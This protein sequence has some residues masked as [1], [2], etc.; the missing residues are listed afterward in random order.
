MEEEYQSP[1]NAGPE[2]I[3]EFAPAASP[4]GG[5]TQTEES[6][7]APEP[8]FAASFLPT[9]QIFRDFGRL[10]VKKAPL[11]R[12]YLI[13][14]LLCCLAYAVLTLVFGPSWLFLLGAGAVWLLLWMFMGEI[15][16]GRSW[17][18][19]KKA[20]RNIPVDFVFGSEGMTGRNALAESRIR[21]SALTDVREGDW[22]YALYLN[23]NQAQLLP[24]GSFT[25]GTAEEFGDYLSEKIGKPIPYY[26]TEGH[27]WLKLL[28]GLL[29]FA[30]LASLSFLPMFQR[31]K[32]QSYG[33]PGYCVVLPS[34][35]ILKQDP[36]YDFYANREDSGIYAYQVSK[37]ELWAYLGRNLTLEEYAAMLAKYARV[38][39]SQTFTAADGSCR[40]TYTMTI[41]GRNYFFYDVVSEGSETFW[42]T[43]FVC[44]AEDRDSYLKVFPKWAD[45]IHC[46]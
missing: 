28:A 23:R 37:Q 29:A 12:F 19:Q 15:I 5:T 24:K 7:S 42:E 41:Q 27:V 10:H 17:R 34:D 30:L 39:Q 43:T 9:K 33:I 11:A 35:F 22:V 25:E 44:F 14:G 40:M 4:E 21:Y 45:T 2:E 16:G 3:P 6:A 46:D 32:L 38:D 36:D 1:L 13:A 31:T 20:G 26:S 8:H 18:A